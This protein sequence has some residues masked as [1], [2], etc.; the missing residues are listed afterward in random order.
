MQDEAEEL[1]IEL[2]IVDSENRVEK[3]AADIEDLLVRDVDLMF[4]APWD[5]DAIIPSIEKV[6]EADIPVM[7]LDR[8]SNG[9]EILSHA[10][11]DQYCFG[12]RIIDYMAELMGEE[13][14]LLVVSGSAGMTP[15][16]W[17]EAGVAAALEK[18]PDIEFLGSYYTDW[19]VSKA[20][21][22]TEDMLTAHPDIA[23]IYSTWDIMTPGVVQALRERDLAG[24]VIVAGGGYYE[25]VQ[26]MIEAGEVHA[27]VFVDTYNGARVSLKAAYEYLVNGVEPDPWT[28]WPGIFYTYDGQE[29]E[30][31]CPV[32]GMPATLP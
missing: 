28:A 22:I 6:N 15:I 13:G 25:E 20:L 21:S 5:A 11:I 27:D 12:Y 19:D 1:G 16:V 2:I 18:Y 10:A 29:Y 23:G 26:P 31:Q 9:G 7:T 8:G 3:Q 32:E 14:K 24:E 4:I 30:V 17:N